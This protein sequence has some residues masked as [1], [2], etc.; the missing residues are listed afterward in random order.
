MWEKQKNSAEITDHVKNI[1]SDSSFSKQALKNKLEKQ[2]PQIPNY[3]PLRFIITFNGYLVDCSDSFLDFISLPRKNIIGFHINEFCSFKSNLQ[4]LDNL[5]ETLTEHNSHSFQYLTHKNNKVVFYKVVPKFDQYTHNKY[6]IF[7]SCKA[8]SIITDFSDIPKSESDFIADLL[9]EMFKDLNEGVFVCL[10]D[11]VIYWNPKLLEILDF[12]MDSEDINKIDMQ[13][14]IMELFDIDFI[15]QATDEMQTKTIKTLHGR[16]KYIEIKIRNKGYLNKNVKIVLLTDKSE[17]YRF[18]KELLRFS[19]ITEQAVEAIM[20]TNPAGK[21]QYVNPAFEKLF[22][23]SKKEILEKTPEFL[24]NGNDDRFDYDKVMQ[25][26]RSGKIWKGRLLNKNKSGDVME[27]EAT[28]SP[29]IDQNGNIINFITV[30]K[31]ITE[32]RRLE[33]Q[34]QQ[35]QK[36]EAIGTLAGGIAHDFNNILTAIIGFTE[37]VIRDESCSKGIQKKLNRVLQ[38]GLRAKDLAKQ[39]LAFNRQTEQDKKNIQVGLIIKEALKLL[40]ASLPTTIEIRQDIK[41]ISGIIF[42]N[43]TQIHQI[44]M[45]LCTNASHAMRERGGVLEVILDFVT[46]DQENSSHYPDLNQGPYL[47]LIVRDTGYGMDEKTLRRIFEPY[48]TTKK[49]GEG[50]GMGLAVVHGI[51]Q[52]HNGAIYVDSNVGLG[53]TFEVLFPRVDSNATKENNTDQSLIGGNE[54]ILFVDDEE[55][56]VEVTQ[57][58]LQELGYSVCAKTSSLDALDEFTENA[59]KYDLVISDQTMPGITGAELADEMFSIKPDIP[60]ILCTGFSD[61]ITE[62][63]AIELGIKRFL[64]KPVPMH[65]FAITIRQVLDEV[66]EKSLKF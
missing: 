65:D 60:F 21:I 30:E 19:A 62:D 39:I 9:L 20:V 57:H 16:E 11:K 32:L 23:Y 37:L 45:N 17:Q 4:F 6:F 26:V 53:T 63:K 27:A 58:I 25:I 49:I 52:A 12:P 44:L 43:P 13:N 36:L 29:V 56:L 10:Q 42:A 31:D 41:A 14:T 28:F 3:T 64:I 54:R 35:S 18:K 51:V 46:I 22:G 34:L 40:R 2:T 47:R 61:V 8:P 38:A 1:F 59:G 7:E 24:Y 15:N 48:F 66:K 55:A 5:N 50:T 33:K